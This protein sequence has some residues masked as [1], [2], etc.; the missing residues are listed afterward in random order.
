MVSVHK[1]WFLS[2]FEEVV[3]IPNAAYDGQEFPV[4]DRVILLCAG[5]FLEVESY[6]VLWSWVFYAIRPLDRWSS[7]IQ[8]C[9]GCY[10]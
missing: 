4:V 2:T 9:S 10:L 1:Y 3:P 7:L 5:E 8:Y 6:R